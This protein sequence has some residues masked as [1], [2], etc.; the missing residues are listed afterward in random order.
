MNHKRLQ[1]NLLTHEICFAQ[2]IGEVDNTMQTLLRPITVQFIKKMAHPISLTLLTYIIVLRN[3]LT[4]TRIPFRAD[5][6]YT[7]QTKSIA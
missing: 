4:C 3:R 7:K 6:H 2:S 1:N 5:G